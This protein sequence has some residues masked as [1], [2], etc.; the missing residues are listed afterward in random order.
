LQ[1]SRGAWVCAD[2][3][4]AGTPTQRS[5]VML[6]SRKPLNTRIF[7]ATLAQRSGI[8]CIEHKSSTS[9]R[10]ACGAAAPGR[11]ARSRLS[12]CC[13]LLCCWTLRTRLLLRNRCRPRLARSDCSPAADSRAVWL[14][15]L[16]PRSLEGPSHD[17]ADDRWPIYPPPAWHSG[18]SIHI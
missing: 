11:R 13:W 10:P 5:S 9:R 3:G 15:S 6:G 12:A 16:N 8:V 7:R 2:S 17:A 14:Y 4:L 1:N 18:A